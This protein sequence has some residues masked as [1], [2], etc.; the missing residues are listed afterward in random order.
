MARV[1]SGGAGRARGG[2]VVVAV[3]DVVEG[4]VGER[5][6]VMSMATREMGRGGGFLKKEGLGVKPTSAGVWC[7]LQYVFLMKQS[8]GSEQDLPWEEFS[9]RCKRGCF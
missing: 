4:G 8:V 2:E 3:V 1:I 5:V 7:I 6:I 9:C